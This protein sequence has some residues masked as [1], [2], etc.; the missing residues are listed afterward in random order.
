[1][2][3]EETMKKAVLA[4]AILLL[5]VSVAWSQMG[6]QA[7]P[8]MMQGSQQPEEQEYEGWHGGCAGP[9]GMGPGMMGHGYGMGPGMM[10]Y[11]YG[12]GPGMMGYGWGM[13]P[14][15]MG[16]GRWGMGPGMMGYGCGMGPGMM[17]YGWGMGPGM[18]YGRGPGYYG[19]YSK[20]QAEKEKKFLDETKDL[21][22]QL[23][24]KRFDYME[25]ARNPK[26]S[27]E[28]LSKLRKEIGDLYE[29]IYKKSPW[30]E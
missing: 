5:G 24:M 19:H 2:K 4:L 22:K 12:M 15:M 16:Y 17:G 10:G 30:H 13:G 28:T 11:G 23:Y 25:A 6:S 1:V 29:E 20:E 9:Y 21:R 26:T 18:M 8:G 7:G 3:K 27:A 14:G